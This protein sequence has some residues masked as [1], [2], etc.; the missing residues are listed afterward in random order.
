MTDATELETLSGSKKPIS[1]ADAVD[2]SFRRAAGRNKRNKHEGENAM[3]RIP[4]NLD[5]S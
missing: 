4:I 1:R 3:I 2:Y 5:L